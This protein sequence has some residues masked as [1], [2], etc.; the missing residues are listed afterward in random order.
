MYT[1]YVPV[2]LQSLQPHT[3]G[4]VTARLPCILPLKIQ[5]L[6]VFFRA[7]F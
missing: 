4:G 7:R 2:N 1:I 5:T 3:H 6:L